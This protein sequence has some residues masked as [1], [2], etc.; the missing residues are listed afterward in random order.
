MR[1]FLCSA[2]YTSWETVGRLKH[3]KSNRHW[4]KLL[5]SHESRLRL[6]AKS[7]PMSPLSGL[8]LAWVNYAPYLPL[9]PHFSTGYLVLDAN[10]LQR[11][12]LGEAHV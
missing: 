11:I 6:F 2:W 8:V 1:Y 5:E 7:N 12:A 3:K 10:T 4:A 9:S